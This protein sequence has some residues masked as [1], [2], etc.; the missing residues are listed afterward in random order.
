MLT[1]RPLK[2]I[3]LDYAK[4]FDLVPIDV[5]MRLAS[6]RGMSERILRPLRGMYNKLQR[7]FK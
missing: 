6:E 2:G 3:S 4:C 1:G 7:R 5:V